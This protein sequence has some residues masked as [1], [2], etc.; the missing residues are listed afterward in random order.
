MRIQ[1]KTH[2]RIKDPDIRAI[3]LIKR[4]M[5]I[6]TPRM[7]QA[8]LDFVLNRDWREFATMTLTNDKKGTQ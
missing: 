2:S 3:Y 4:A 5:E 7:R 8:N 6:S 1:I